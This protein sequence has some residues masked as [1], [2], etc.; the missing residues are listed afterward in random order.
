MLSHDVAWVNCYVICFHFFVCCFLSPPAEMA[1]STVWA[2]LG[3][4]DSSCFKS[5]ASQMPTTVLRSRADSTTNKY[6]YAYARW[7]K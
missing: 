7:K 3:E 4:I 5:L 1:V 2:W 6:L